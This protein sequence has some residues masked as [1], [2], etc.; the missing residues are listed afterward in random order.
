MLEPRDRRN[1]PGAGPPLTATAVTLNWHNIRSYE[2]ARCSTLARL[3]RQCLMRMNPF[4]QD[5]CSE[6]SLSSYTLLPD[7]AQTQFKADYASCVMHQDGHSPLDQ[8]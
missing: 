2:L 8:P 7:A 3:G 5:A 4:D 6:A 1:M